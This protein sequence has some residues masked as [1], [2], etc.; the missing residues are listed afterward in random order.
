VWTC[1]SAIWSSLFAQLPVVSKR[2]EEEEEESSDSNSDGVIIVDIKGSSFS[3]SKSLFVNL[4]NGKYTWLMTRENWR[5]VKPKTSHTKYVS[6]DDEDENEESLLSDMSKICKA[7]IK[8]FL[9]QVGFR[10]ELLEEREK[11]L[12]QEKE[13]N[14]EFQ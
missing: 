10:D 5:K 6:S 4:N 7:R 13:S 2:E 3:S 1:I 8:G 14:K 11:L 9:S 12:I